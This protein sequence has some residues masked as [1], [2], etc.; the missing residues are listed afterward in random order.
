VEA[1]SQ[2]GEVLFHWNS[3]RSRPVDEAR[4]PFEQVLLFEPH[5][6]SALIHL[7]RIA[8]TRGRFAEMDSLAARALAEHPEA[9]TAREMRALRA[10]GRGDTALWRAFGQ[11]LALVT[12]DEPGALL[13][14]ILA[15]TENLAGAAELARMLTGFPG[16]NL[17]LQN[18]LA[19][20]EAEAARGRWLE[21]ERALGGMG[22]GSM[23]R[24]AE[25]RALFATLPTRALPPGELRRLREALPHPASGPVPIGG[26][27]DAIG[28]QSIYPPRAL[29]LRG[30][31]SARAGDLAAAAGYAAELERFTSGNFRDD[32]VAHDCARTLRAQVALQQGDARGALALLGT[33]GTTVD[34]MLPEVPSYPLAQA[35][36][37]RAE[38]LRTLGRPREALLVY[39]S[40]PDPT[41]YD[42][43]YAPLAHLRRGELHER[44][45]ERRQAAG[46]Y[47]RA[48][49]GWR[50]ADPELRGLIDAARRGAARTSGGGS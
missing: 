21:A 46:E 36:W 27:Y 6:T 29:Y 37:V 1:W 14:S 24:A 2:L 26:R 35:R 31:L 5:N 42:V 43:M 23:P 3:S 15:H 45:G 41:G 11:E 17:R 10:F 9:H 48:L 19:A 30:L 47:A 33:P 32:G 18:G 22:L 50:D 38:A 20:S 16:G 39:A 7:A 28:T 34:S 44:L 49:A 25:Y 40:F 12:G 4:R 13:H 8:G